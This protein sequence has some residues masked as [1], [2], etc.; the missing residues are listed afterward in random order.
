MTDTGVQFFDEPH[1]MQPGSVA[2]YLRDFAAHLTGQGYRSL[3]IS[4][5]L[6]PALHFGGWIDANQI[7]LAAV[8]NETSQVFATIT[9]NVLVTKSSN[10]FHDHTSPGPSTSLSISEG[11]M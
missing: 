8:T 3:R 9:V 1:V 6:W 4:N 2:E 7:P 10:T 5:Y 11:G